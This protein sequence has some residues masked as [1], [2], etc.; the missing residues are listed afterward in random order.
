M[1]SWM[2]RNIVIGVG[3]AVLGFFLISLFAYLEL[4]Y[5]EFGA[6]MQGAAKGVLDRRYGDPFDFMGKW[7]RI[8][9]F[10]MFPVVSVLVGLFIGSL[11]R[12]RCWLA[13]L[14]GVTPIVFVNYPSNIVSVVSGLVCIFAAW[15]GAKSAQA[16]LRRFSE[17]RETRTA[18]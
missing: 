1:S 10:I 2:K 14:I 6:F 13:V 7:A 4:R 15:L 16:I 12:A 17:S 9:Q 11:C 18:T 3:A 8:N 5:T